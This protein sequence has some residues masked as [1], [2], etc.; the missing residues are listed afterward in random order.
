MSHPSPSRALNKPFSVPNSDVLEIFGLTV[1]LG[2]TGI[3]LTYFLSEKEMYTQRKC[4][5]REMLIN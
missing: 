2:Q 1:Y 4:I 3:L 5:Y